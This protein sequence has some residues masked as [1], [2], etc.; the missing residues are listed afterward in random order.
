MVIRSKLSFNSPIDN[1]PPTPILNGKTVYIHRLWTNNP[2]HLLIRDLIDIN[3]VQ[4]I[5]RLHD[6]CN[7]VYVRLRFDEDDLIQHDLFTELGFIQVYGEYHEIALANLIECRSILLK[8]PSYFPFAHQS[9][10][11]D[12]PYQFDPETCL[13]STNLLE[14]LNKLQEDEGGK[15]LI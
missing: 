15:D 4:R 1:D 6:T 2:D 14:R 5:N 7:T 13:P 3:E 8:K 11:V 12:D 10:L 9:M